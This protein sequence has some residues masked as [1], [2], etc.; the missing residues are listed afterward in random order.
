[1]GTFEWRAFFLISGGLRRAIPTYKFLYSQTNLVQGWVTWQIITSGLG[2]WTCAIGTISWVFSNPDCFKYAL[3]KWMV[4]QAWLTRDVLASRPG[5]PS[6]LPRPGLEA[7]K[8]QASASVR[9]CGLDSRALRALGLVGFGLEPRGALEAYNWNGT[10]CAL[11]SKSITNSH[12]VSLAAANRNNILTACSASV[13][14]LR[15]AQ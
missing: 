6:P 13:T 1:M 7:E 12:E 14:V 3:A 11:G 15:G 2:S 4:R 10:E 5:S 9:A 8:P